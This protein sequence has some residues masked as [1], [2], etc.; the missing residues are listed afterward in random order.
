MSTLARAQE[1]L[2]LDVNKPT[3]LNNAHNTTQISQFARTYKGKLRVVVDV[4]H[5]STTSNTYS[6]SQCIDVRTRI[7]RQLRAAGVQVDERSCK[8]IPK[9]TAKDRARFTIVVY[10][11]GQFPVAK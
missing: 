10:H 8:I 7:L 3:E 5:D 11:D 4:A 9:R 6:V 1:I 2:Y